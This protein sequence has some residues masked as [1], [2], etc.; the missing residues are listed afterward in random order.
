LS[1]RTGITIFAVSG[2]AEGSVVLGQP[3]FGRKT[4]SLEALLWR[5]RHSKGLFLLGA[6]AST[7]IVPFGSTF[8]A[9][10][11]IDFHDKFTSLSGSPMMLLGQNKG[12]VGPTRRRSRELGRALAA[13]A[14]SV[15]LPA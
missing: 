12:D 2:A 8:M 4:I 15:V 13:Q 3:V 6:G 9:A 10:P 7:G 1:F 11:A 14:G 5:F